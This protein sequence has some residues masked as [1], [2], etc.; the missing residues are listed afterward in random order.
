MTSGAGP[1]MTSGVAKM[2]SKRLNLFFYGKSISING[3]SNIS[4]MNKMYEILLKDYSE[5]II[6]LLSSES[7]S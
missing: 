4:Y 2:T 3:I 1:G 5:I 6:R 7:V